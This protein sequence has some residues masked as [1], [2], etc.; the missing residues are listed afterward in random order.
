MA[1]RVAVANPKG[2]VGKSL[3]TMM[4]ADGLALRGARVLVIDMDPQAGVT[5]S[6]LGITSHDDLAA[7]KI[8]LG[9]ILEQWARGIE[10]RFATH[11]VP[12]GDLIELRERQPG[13]IDLIPSNNELLGEMVN[14]EQSL[15]R[16]KRKERA[17]LTIASLLRAALARIER[18]YDLIMFDCPA[19]PV[20]LGLAAIRTA[21]HIL[22]PTSLEEN[23]YSTLRD[24]IKFML[25]DDLGLAEQVEVHPM[26]TQFHASN[27]IQRQM[28]DHLNSG[29]YALNAIPRPIPYATALQAAAR[30][31]GLGAFRSMREKYGS[32]LPDVVALSEAVAKRI[33]LKVSRPK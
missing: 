5:K 30:H 31:P 25:A 7:R 10:I 17:D 9:P 16:M 29:V 15:H 21:S 3:S 28:L 18:N 4:L 22:T 13:F 24:F 1:I 19:G 20:P 2:G 8:G 12:A 27:P 11:R 32:T 26:I 6:L 23:S 14:F 33:Q